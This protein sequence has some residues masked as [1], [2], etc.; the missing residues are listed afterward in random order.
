[1]VA[2]YTTSNTYTELSPNASHKELIV[3]SPSTAAASDVIQINLADHGFSDT[4]LLTVTGYKHTTA[5]SV[6]VVDNPTTTTAIGILSL[7]ITTAVPTGYTRIYRVVG[8]SA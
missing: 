7:T 6:V 8:D 2:T 3:I 1:M 5:N 4:G